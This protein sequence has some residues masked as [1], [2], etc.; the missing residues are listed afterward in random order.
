MRTGSKR[1]S[2]KTVRGMVQSAG[3]AFSSSTW[4]K[5][6]DKISSVVLH[7]S[8]ESTLFIH[9]HRW[10]ACDDLVLFNVAHALT[11]GFCWMEVVCRWM[12]T[13]FCKMET[14]IVEYIEVPCIYIECKLFTNPR[15]AMDG[16]YMGFRSRWVPMYMCNNFAQ[17]PLGTS[18]SM[19]RTI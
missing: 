2:S 6:K 1:L 12:G 10:D 9:I 18:Y 7:L 3:L 11:R 13:L 5:L 14:L 15:F 17:C 16:P 8:L 19:L 4:K